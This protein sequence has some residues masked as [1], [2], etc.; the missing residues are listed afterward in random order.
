M[1]NKVVS[2][3]MVIPLVLMFCVFSASNIA[4]LSVPIAVSSVSVFHEE[5]E[6]VNLAESDEFQIN[7]QV[8][9][10]NASNKGLIYT[11]EN[12]NKSLI[13]EE[14][15]LEINE[16]GLV[17]AKGCGTAKIT[18]ETKDGAYKKSFILEVVSTKATDII[19]N[20]NKNGDIFVGD[21]FSYLANV[22]PETTLDKSVVFSSSDS[23][24]VKVNSITG[25][26]TAVSNGRATITATLENGLNGQIQKSV[27]V[28]VFP[29]QT[30]S[31][32]TFEG[33][34]NISENIF[35]DSYFVDMNINFTAEYVLGKTLTQ[36]EV[37]LDYD[38]T[39]VENVKISEWI[40]NNGVY[41]CKLSITGIE[42]D[43]NLK[44]SV[45]YGEAK[46]NYSEINLHKVVDLN[47]LNVEV[48]SLEKY[49]KLNSVND[50]L[51]NV[52]PEDFDEYEII[53]SV[54]NNNISVQK[55]ET[56]YYI[57]GSSIGESVLTV[58]IISNNQVIKTI[59][60]TITVLNP[61]TSINFSESSKTYGIE[62]LLTIGDKEIN[63]ITNEIKEDDY[64]DYYHSFG[65]T[66]NVNL[67][68]IEFE[69]SDESI[70]RF[71]QNKE[72][73][74][75][76]EG[77]VT[78]TATEQESKLLGN[79]V[80]CSIEIRCVNGV[81]LGTYKE[82]NFAVND[83]MQVVLTND[84]MLG[85][86]LIHVNDD[87]TTK[88]LYSQAE[89]ERILKS[90][91]KQMKTT[92]D[93]N[94]YKNAL[95]YSEPPEINYILKFTN[96]CFGNGYQLNANNIT[97]C[98]KGDTDKVA[99]YDFAQFRGPLD[100]VA[101]VGKEG[102]SSASVKAQDNVCFIASDNVMLNNVEL[103]GSNMR[104]AS[105]TDLNQ[106]NYVGTVLE[107]MGDNVKIV[108]SRVRNGRNCI[109]VYGKEYGKAGKI[110]VHIE[111][112]I[113]SHAREFL[114]KLGTNEKLP[115]NFSAAGS[116][117]LKDGNLADK[118]WEECSPTLDN[119]THLNK[120]S[121]T[122]SQYNSLVQDYL[123]NTTYQELV[124]TTLTLKNSVLHTSGLFS[125]GIESS[126]AG[127]ALDGGRW[128]S[129]N[130]AELGWL[131]LA[132]T[133]YPAQLNLEG[134]VKI[135]DWKKLSHI[136]SSILLDGDMFN[137]DLS[138]M[139][140]NLYNDGKFNDIITEVN[141]EKYAHGGIVMYGGG[142]NYSLIN[143]NMTT[144]KLNNYSINLDSLNNSLTT[145]LKYASG[146]ENFRMFMYG[147]NSSFNYYKQVN[148]MNS[149]LA[150]R[151]VGKY[152]F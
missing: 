38:E 97:N 54:S 101:L 129:F 60:E 5:Q 25:E 119:L 136:D 84:I 63:N 107:A 13:Q 110:N 115:G 141:G 53:I 105:V 27:E 64:K 62:N 67:D 123:T 148:D 94:Y 108:N 114:I 65:F 90:E 109:R 72:L 138:S 55:G 23:S 100:L 10:K 35:S 86:K 22:I 1:K 125:V 71:N 52:L 150:F 152:T 106:L 51:V 21:K 15:F 92:A 33:Q 144:E 74:I 140:N 145:M 112:S 31:L 30:S 132:G 42:S 104:G 139:I 80:S 91:I 48:T 46:N 85:E 26:C 149:G 29:K 88:L 83:D 121:L 32:I 113:I 133:S 66:T 127:P 18:V 142:K 14:L 20:V 79:N 4:T 147:K 45:N 34:D 9:P 68:N 96:N 69:S 41:K 131:D 12:L 49:I 70:A 77:K 28:I 137:L 102:N 7:A 146:R 89:C 44:V 78:I 95:N 118:Y 143:D 40:N 57:M 36:E 61:P 56:A 122:K 43:L 117:N 16:T 87:G 19:A 103:V 82:L 116:I 81:N 6:V 126:F 73:E 58:E 134:N 98:L 50:F 111:S 2:L 37:I 128:G 151:E 8:Y 130:F 59:S 124:K 17:K 39:L 93:W 76:S 11:Y 120:G 3:I 24:V 99:Y 47:E 75:L 135:Y